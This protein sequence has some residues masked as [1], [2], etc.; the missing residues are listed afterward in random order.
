VIVVGGG[1]AGGAAAFHLAALGRA[2]LVLDQA[3][4]PRH[5]PCGGGMAA[6][7]Q[8]WFPFNL[9]P[10]VEAVIERVRFSWDLNDPVIAELP[11]SS[12]FWIVRRS[13]L[14]AF[15]RGL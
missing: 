8:Q 2:V 11:G 1:A 13:R 5:K 7:V 4:F 15:R 10:A 9:T 3:P 14:D 6:S 12:P